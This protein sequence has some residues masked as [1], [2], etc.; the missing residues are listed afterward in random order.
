MSSSSNVLKQLNVRSKDYLFWAVKKRS[1]YQTLPFQSNTKFKWHKSK[2]KKETFLKT[3]NH[4]FKPALVT[5]QEK[6][7]C[8]LLIHYYSVDCPWWFDRNFCRI[9]RKHF[10]R[11]ITKCG[12]E[13]LSFNEFFFLAS[14]FYRDPNLQ[15]N[16]EV[17]RM[18]GSAWKLNLI[19]NFNSNCCRLSRFHC[20]W[21]QLATTWQVLICLFWKKLKSL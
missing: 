5:S 3:Y 19:Q 7:Q 10:F 6:A 18:D 17:K 4:K 8:T 20:E 1:N 2:T 14:S 16:L 15:I 9:R 11:Q 13:F 12:H 21:P